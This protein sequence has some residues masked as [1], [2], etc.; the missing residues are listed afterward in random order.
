MRKKGEAER[1]YQGR[2]AAVDGCIG[3]VGVGVDVVDCW[4]SHI[5]AVRLLL[6]DCGIVLW[7]RCDVVGHF[8]RRCVAGFGERRGGLFGCGITDWRGCALRENVRLTLLMSHS[9]III[10]YLILIFNINIDTE[11]NLDN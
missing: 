6:W 5:E 9:L 10:R 8:N 2:R 1:K 4:R 7:V 3:S 11:F